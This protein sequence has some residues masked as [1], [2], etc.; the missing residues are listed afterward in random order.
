[1]T[2][3]TPNPRSRDLSWREQIVLA[4]Y[5][6]A[7]REDVA[8]IATASDDTSALNTT[9]HD[10]RMYT[11]ARGGEMR[12]SSAILDHLLFGAAPQARSQLAS[13][14]IELIAKEK[15]SEVSYL[16][17]SGN[18]RASWH[19]NW[20]DISEKLKVMGYHGGDLNKAVDLADD[21][22]LICRNANLTLRAG[23]LLS[24]SSA[25]KLA[26][27]A[28]NELVKDHK[29]LSE[30]V[31]MG[32]YPVTPVTFKSHNYN[33]PLQTTDRLSIALLLDPT[34][35][36]FEKELARGT[37]P[38]EAT[39]FYNIGRLALPE[40]YQVQYSENP[41]Q[42]R[43]TVAYLKQQGFDINAKD[44][45]GR[46]ALTRLMQDFRKDVATNDRIFAEEIFG[47]SDRIISIFK[48]TGA[49]GKIK[50]NTG[51]SADNYR[52]GAYNDH[53][54][55]ETLHL[56]GIEAETKARMQERVLKLQQLA[57]QF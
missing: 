24:P 30:T 26:T 13:Y 42:V 33:T 47:K 40:R 17:S 43:D 48:E 31:A 25:H 32:F 27:V 7:D 15:D 11:L 8:D 54:V 6:K 46:T 4:T 18:G 16:L 50:D 3:P 41:T 49:S 14:G 55:K 45:E 20:S 29:L 34:H 37:K 51:M 36:L 44:T 5:G 10:S 39:M 2:E 35:K 38:D 21:P 12:S 23:Q 22:H 52:M 1:M 56:A 57:P 28:G 19:D 53:A 9:V